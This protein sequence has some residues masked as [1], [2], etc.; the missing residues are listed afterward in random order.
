MSA[1][2]EYTRVQQVCYFK[3]ISGD[4]LELK[5]MLLE[6]ECKGKSR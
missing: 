6:E 3:D 5:F 4:F 2:L 1:E